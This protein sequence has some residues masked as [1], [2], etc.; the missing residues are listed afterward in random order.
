MEFLMTCDHLQTLIEDYIDQQLDN[1]ESAMLEEHLTYCEYCQ[2][3][4]AAS[5]TYRKQLQAFKAPEL[6]PS[7]AA[8]LLKNA[9]T[10]NEHHQQT[11]SSFIYG[12]V[13]A[14]IL[15]F[16]IMI[17][18]SIFTEI[19]PP[20][21]VGVLDWEKEISLVINVPND[22]SD[23]KLVLNLPSDISI[24]G[25]EHLSTVEWIINLKKGSNTITLPIQV[26]PYASYAEKIQLAASLI[27]KNNKKD[28]SLDLTFDSQNTKNERS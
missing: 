19:Q 6:S 5:L 15:A 23:A 20:G 7:S 28:F 8:R 1:K 16:A 13:A 25:L 11:K 4:Q 21:I 12:F 26:E 10:K 22:M 2:A 18:S 3:T 17:S 27:Y 14:S 24:Q 9:R